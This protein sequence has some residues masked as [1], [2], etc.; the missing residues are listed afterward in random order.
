MHDWSKKGDK[1]IDV[2]E[3]E[4]VTKNF[5]EGWEQ[6]TYREKLHDERKVTNRNEPKMST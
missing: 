5:L 4:R 2:E 6:E 1:Y 3:A